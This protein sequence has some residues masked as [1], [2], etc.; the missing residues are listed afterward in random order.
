MPYNAI[1]DVLN[2]V[3][4]CE[5]NVEYQQIS[6]EEVMGYICKRHKVLLVYFR[7]FRAVISLLDEPINDVFRLL[8][9]IEVRPELNNVIK[10]YCETPI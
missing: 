9:T 5:T 1:G 3:K 4:I 8:Q 7:G 6:P 10:F 2:N